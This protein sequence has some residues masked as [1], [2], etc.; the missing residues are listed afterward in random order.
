MTEPVYR[1]AGPADALA[2]AQLFAQ[3]FTETFGH[4][5]APEDLAAFLGRMDEAGWLAELSDPGLSI[6]IV[7]AEGKA[8]AL[9]KVGTITLP[10]QP[11][12]PAT[13]LRQLYVLKPWQGRGIAEALMAWV[14]DLA[15]ADGAE[16]LYLS[17]YVDNHRARRF[18]TRYG[19]EF[20]GPYAFMVGN[21]AD[22][23]MVLR[24]SLKD[25]Q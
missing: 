16:D 12:R 7:E 21:H 17:V 5:Y 14:L 9:G 15:R 13:E 10:V 19:F 2:L 1:D 4:L 22:E 20:V 18:Y 11:E 25:G 23:D 6:R 8:I 24:L 3:S